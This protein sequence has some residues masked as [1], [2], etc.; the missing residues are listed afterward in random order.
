LAPSRAIS[1]A[2]LR[3]VIEFLAAQ[4]PRPWARAGIGATPPITT[5]A[6]RTTPP[7]FNDRIDGNDGVIPSQTLAYFV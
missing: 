6:S 1:P 2:C 5:R 4:K 7:L 3:T